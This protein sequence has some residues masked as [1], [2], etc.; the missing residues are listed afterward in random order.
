MASCVTWG[1]SLG[2]AVYWAP[3]PGPAP[4]KLDSR[5]LPARLL[6]GVHPS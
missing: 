2:R 4:W 3:R 1:P 6:P 5:P